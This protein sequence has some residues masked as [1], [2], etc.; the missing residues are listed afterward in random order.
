MLRL[1]LL[2]IMMM[3]LFRDMLLLSELLV[4]NW[5]L[6]IPSYCGQE[7]V[8]ISIGFACMLPNLSLAL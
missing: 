5:I 1:S 2:F 4:K 8:D 7:A 3:V 6:F